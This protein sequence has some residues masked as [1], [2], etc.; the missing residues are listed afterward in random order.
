MDMD[1]PLNTLA[2][3]SLPCPILASSTGIWR[4]D[5]VLE[6]GSADSRGELKPNLLHE[7]G[8][9]LCVCVFMLLCFRSEE[10]QRARG[11]KGFRAR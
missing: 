3:H 1:I 10:G 2:K 6:T 5:G 7:A 8:A 9:N 4:A 11:A